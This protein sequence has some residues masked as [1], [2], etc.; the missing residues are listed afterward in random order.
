[1]VWLIVSMNLAT[2]VS[3]D[4]IDLM[5]FPTPQEVSIRFSSPKKTWT[6]L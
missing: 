6:S 2:Y 5:F 1:M 4:F 3:S